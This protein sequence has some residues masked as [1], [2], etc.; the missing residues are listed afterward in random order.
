MI[1]AGNGAPA[2]RRAGGARR[3]WPAPQGCRRPGRA[4]AGCGVFGRQL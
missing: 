3:G 2:D 4:A 1:A